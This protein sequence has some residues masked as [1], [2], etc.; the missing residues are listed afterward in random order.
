MTLPATCYF[1][2]L[3]Y[4]SSQNKVDIIVSNKHYFA[5]IE[6]VFGGSLWLPCTSS[7]STTSSNITVNEKLSVNCHKFKKKIP[8]TPKLYI[9]IHM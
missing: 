3:T 9:I 1:F 4:F 6:N 8:T 5:I 7:L 2:N